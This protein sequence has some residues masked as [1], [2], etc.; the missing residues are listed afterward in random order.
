MFLLGRVELLDIRVSILPPGLEP[1]LVWAVDKT[2]EESSKSIA[3]LSWEMKQNFSSI[4]PK[5][6]YGYVYFVSVSGGYETQV[7]I[8]LQNKSPSTWV[9]LWMPE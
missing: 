1:F 7:Q 2:S 8:Q 4:S 9:N 5:V 3:L 6:G